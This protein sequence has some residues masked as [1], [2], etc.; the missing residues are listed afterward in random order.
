MQPPP[1]CWGVLNLLPIFSNKEGGFTKPQFLKEVAGKK[2]SSNFYIKNKL[3]SETFRGGLPKKG[4]ALTVCI[5]RGGGELGKKEE[6]GGEGW[7][8]GGRGGDTLM[9]IMRWI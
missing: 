1:F 6:R 5:F 2:G 7:E 4:G 9:H 3:K 8:R